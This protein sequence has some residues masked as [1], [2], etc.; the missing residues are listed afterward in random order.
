MLNFDEQ[1][2]LRIQSGAVALRQRLDDVVVSC[3]EKG[4]ENVFFLGTGGAAILMRPAAQLLQRRSR[5]PAFIDLPAELFI[6]GSV[7]LTE[8]SIVVIPS[9]SGTTKESVA[10][11]AKAKEAGATVLSLVGHE[12]TP[13]GKGGDHAFVNFAEDDTSCESFYLQSLFIALSIMRHRGEIENYDQIA[14]ELERLPGLLL[15]VKRG[16]EDKAETFAR[17]LAG[18][19]Y[20]IVTGAGNAWP[21]AFYYGM[22][23][24]EEMQWIRTRPVHAS[25]FFHGTLELVEKG[26]SVILF[27]GE[28]ALRPL[29]DRV[30]NFA[31]NYTDRLTVLDT[32]DFALPGISQEVRGL[33]SP[34]VLATVLERISAHLEVMRNHPLTT[35]R[36]YKRVA[37]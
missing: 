34:I 35:R 20:H 14:G 30:Q 27:K 18:S 15:E 3:L 26:V 36:Y 22:C 6:T 1:R 10:L 19:D 13:L 24:L 4:A 11:L 33:V 25:D 17:V 32:A 8:K 29:A 2:F 28:D 12:E 21:E 9:L 31:P 7:N 5:F 23:I 37:Y 16:Y